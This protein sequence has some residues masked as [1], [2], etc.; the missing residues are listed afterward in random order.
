[1]KLLTNPEG[2]ADLIHTSGFFRIFPERANSMHCQF[3][4]ALFTNSVN[5][6]RELVL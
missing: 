5:S 4:T 1:M 3:S 2:K 6:S